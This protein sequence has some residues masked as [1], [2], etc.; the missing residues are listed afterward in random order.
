MQRGDLKV[1]VVMQPHSGSS[2]SLIRAR[3]SQYMQGQPAKPKGKSA[4]ATSVALLTGA[5]L[6]TRK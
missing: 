5:P 3:Y 6:S 2:E 1:L 4:V